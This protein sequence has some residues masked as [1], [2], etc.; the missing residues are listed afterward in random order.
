MVVSDSRLGIIGVLLLVAGCSDGTEVRDASMRRDATSLDASVED[1]APTLEDGGLDAPVIVVD[2]AGTDTPS[3]DAFETDDVW[4]P[5]VFVGTDAWTPDAFVPPDAFTPPPDVGTDAARPD[6]GPVQCTP[7]LECPA[8]TGLCSDTAPGGVCSCFSGMDACPSGTTCDTE[9]GAC[10]RSCSTDLD[11]S[12]GMSCTSLTGR[13][14]IRRCSETIACPAPYVCSNPI[15]GFCRR[16]SCAGG[17][18]C[19][20]RMTCVG[21]VCVE[22]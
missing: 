7:A 18:A 4:W 6:L 20:S 5:D 22:M 15:A 8:G 14:S 1:D 17:A 19:P 9:I 21:D 11:C 10:V 2:D 3:I 16:P 12:A 13:C